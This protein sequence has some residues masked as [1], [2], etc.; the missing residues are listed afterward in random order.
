MADVKIN[1]I[2]QDSG[3][4]NKKTGEAKALNQELT[5][6]QKLARGIPVSS[7][8]RSGGAFAASEMEDFNKAR[9]A[10]GTGAA[11][12][13]FANQAQGLGGLV[14]VY[15]TFAAN[16]FA[17]TAAF[18]ALKNA[19]DTTN[20][21]KGL[22]QL[23]VASGVNLP[24]IAKDLEAA[25]GGAISLRDAMTATAQSS[26]AGMTGDSIRRMGEVAR[27][28]SQALGVDMS[29]ALDRLSR[30]ITK[31][32]PELL[33]E[34][35]IFTRTEQAAEDYARAV[36]K[37]VGSLTSFEK[38]QA[39]ANAVLAEGEQKFGAIA[40]QTNPYNK[41]LATLKNVTQAGLELVNKVLGP[42]IDLL[43][44]SP[45]ALAAILGLV[46]TTLFK[47]AIPAVTQWRKELRDSAED[48]AKVTAQNLE[49]FRNYQQS[50]MTGIVQNIDSAVKAQADGAK[51][52]WT[53]AQE[54][55]K[56]S[57]LAGS[58]NLK[59][60]LKRDLESATKQD[61]EALD[62][63][64]KSYERM[65]SATYTSDPSKGPAAQARLQEF[66]KL[67]PVLRQAINSQLEFNRAVEA[68][69]PKNLSLQ[70][71]LL[72]KVADDAALAEKRMNILANAADNAS[73]SGPVAAFKSLY[74]E[75]TKLGQD[76]PKKIGLVSTAML[77]L[78]GTIAITAS[79]VGLLTTA[80]GNILA[81]IGIVVG[82]FTLLSSVLSK[83]GEE[84]QK[85]SKSLD[86]LKSS[87][88]NLDRVFE[89]LEKKTPLQRLNAD[90]IAATA[91]ATSELAASFNK[92]IKDVDASIAA[93]NWFDSFT[94]GLSFIIGRSEEQ[95]I[96]KSLTKQLNK[97]LKNAT[98]SID[99]AN[100]RNE[101]VK[102]MS[103]PEAASDETIVRRFVNN[104]KTFAPQFQKLA[105]AFEISSKSGK[106]F[107]DNLN[108][109]KKTFQDLKN[110][111]LP[112]GKLIDAITQS[113]SVFSDLVKMFDGPVT[114]SL[115]N[116][117]NL[118][119][120][121]QALSMLP[122]GARA[123]LLQ[124]TPAIDEISNRMANNQVVIAETTNKLNKYI[125][126]L[127]NLEKFNTNAMIETSDGKISTR[128]ERKTELAQNI[129]NLQRDLKTAFKETTK[130]SEVVQGYQETFRKAISYGFEANSKLLETLF[131][132]TIAKARIQTEQS[133]LSKLPETEDVIKR[134]SE[135][136]KRQIDLDVQSQVLQNRLILA[137][138]KTAL[139]LE[140]LQKEIALDRELRQPSGIRDEKVEDAIRNQIKELR[141]RELGLKEIE[142]GKSPSQAQFQKL[143]IDP[144]EALRLTLL[145][146][147]VAAPIA[148]GTEQKRAIDLEA[149]LRVFNLRVGDASEV[150]KNQISGI[151]R[152]IQELGQQRPANLEALLSQLNIERAK[153]ETAL[154]QLEPQRQAGVAAIAGAQT[155]LSPEARRGAVQRALRPLRELEKQSSLEI[156]ILDLKEQQRL[157]QIRINAEYD[158]ASRILREQEEL[159]SLEVSNQ[160]QSIDYSLQILD[161]Q[162]QRS[163]IS[164]DEYKQ[165]VFLINQQ[166]IE[167]DLQNR[168]KDLEV[169]RLRRTTEINREVEAKGG[170]GALTAEDSE[171]LG[172]SAAAV[173]T[174][175]NRATQSAKDLRNQSMSLLEINNELSTEQQSLAK[176]YEDTFSRMGD[177]MVDFA[178]TG[179]FSFKSLINDMLA[180]IARLYIN[181]MFSSMFMQFKGFLPGLGG[182]GAGSFMGLSQTG[183]ISQNPFGFAKGGAFSGSIEKYGKGGYFTNS[184]V[185]QPTM[186][187]FARGTGLMGEAGPEAI[188]PLKRDSQGNLGVRGGGGGSV[189]VV[190]NNYSSEKAETRETTDSRGNRKIEVV[191]GDMAAGQMTSS[192]SSTQKALRGAYGLTPQLIRR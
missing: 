143:G 138:E 39:F 140:L 89:S 158:T 32:E 68:A 107:S 76:A 63:L 157:E 93:R 91:T 148:T 191:V 117:N 147:G 150:L 80:L 16:L 119:K 173:G 96:E 182:G 161:I 46:A 53:K 52:A 111:T 101:L 73:F 170:Y 126:E 100:L 153:L 59:K 105:Q 4:I 64:K 145:G 163:N 172:A 65:A 115:A 118:L 175:F 10:V 176:I 66:Q 102:M 55:T 70:G 174:W 109:L 34:V 187:R 183:G 110:E 87:G 97:I 159:R 146:R 74:A 139:Q 112:K 165:R 81:V 78:R 152:S 7:S 8:Q 124:V 48:A 130:D 99:M 149:T 167:V 38:R 37:S 128:F 123:Q 192:G 186:F 26:S 122:E 42:I 54:E 142:S 178:R 136:Q 86:A 51:Q 79:Y 169:E 5:K 116:M 62:K 11:G 120:N 41:L 18:N 20:L 21:I 151:D 180:Q 75:I 160:Q 24:K 25:S 155:S 103:L 28:A 177:A 77:Y 9:G 129:S 23:G 71:K 57:I 56:T 188:M 94:N 162:R 31:L 1:M 113:T 156:N 22:E 35:G 92:A 15:A 83:N 164:E 133:A 12:R 184:I 127:E 69:T 125:T 171:R 137:N 104:Y 144:A 60:F 189:E 98:S 135:L 85:A 43:S 141:K 30:G 6:T 72:Q 166:R 168:L 106:V 36:G 132:S 88:E 44:Q 190:V 84:S 29:N 33:D 2:L 179:K 95:Q 19:A 3:S 40:L 50:A 90:T 114:V 49:Y 121:T 185:A 154:Q 14:R 61:L 17:A 134:Q 67:E 27:N 13:D 58:N 108:E 47:Q 131:A 45:T 181:K 82:T